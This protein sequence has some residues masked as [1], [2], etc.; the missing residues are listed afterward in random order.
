MGKWK[1]MRSPVLIVGLLGILVIAGV[2]A[3]GRSAAAAQAGISGMATV[4]G[5]VDSTGQFRAVALFPGNYEVSVSTKGWESDVQKVALK[6]GDNPKLK[7]SLRAV[8]G[9]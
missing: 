7:L 2:V 6:A 4:S 8:S 9:T 3:G 5:T 1:L